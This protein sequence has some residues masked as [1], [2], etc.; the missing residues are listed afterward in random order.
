MHKL[1]LERRAENDLL[2][3]EMDKVQMEFEDLS[4]WGSVAIMAIDW[5][6]SHDGSLL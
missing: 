5:V 2:V 4:L 6:R 3:M 1:P